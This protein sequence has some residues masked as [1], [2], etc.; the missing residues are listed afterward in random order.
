MDTMSPESHDPNRRAIVDK[1]NSLEASKQA[2]KSRH[3]ELASIS[4]LPCEVLAAIFSFLSVFAL[5]EGSGVLGWIYVA[6][7]CHRWRETALSHRRFRSHINLT[8][9]KLSLAFA[10]IVD[11]G[12]ITMS[13]VFRNG[14]QR[15]IVDE[16]NSLEASTRA[17][18]S[19]LNELAPISCLPFEVLT[20]I[21]TF[22]SVFAWNDC[23][24]ILAW[25][26]AAHICRRWRDAALNHPRFWSHVNFAK[27]TPV[28]MAEILSRAKMAPLHLETDFRS[29]K[30]E[31]HMAFK[32]QFETHISHT[33]HLKFSGDL[34]WHMG[35]LLN[36]PVPTLESLSLSHTALMYQ[37]GDAPTNHLNLTAPS[38]TSLK[39]Q[40]YDISWKSPL[41]KGLRIL[42]IR[43][44]S[45]RPE[46]N[47]WLDALNEMRQLKD[48]TFDNATP[49][50]P[51]TA[52]LISRTVTVPSLTYFYINDRSND[53]AHALAHIS[54]PTLT[55]LHVEVV[56]LRQDGEDTLRLIPFVARHVRALQ[57]NKPMRSILIAGER[58]STSV[59]T[60]ATPGVDV[61]VCGL[62]TLGDMTRSARFLFTVEGSQKY[63]VS[64]T[65]LDTLL[66]LLPMNSISTLSA[67]NRTRLSKESWL[68]HASRLPMLEQARLAP[69]AVRGFTEMLSEDM[70]LNS[71][72][73]RLAMLT[74]LILLD[75]TLTPMR[76]FRLRDILIKCMEQGVPLEC[77]DLRTCASA[78]RTIQ[79]FAEIMVDVQE[80]LAAQPFPQI[81]TESFFKATESFFNFQGGF[82][83]DNEAEFD[84]EK[85][86]WN[87]EG[88][89]D[90]N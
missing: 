64:T 19:R 22:L 84:D 34:K 69:T 40:C 78:N 89:E 18:K 48:L 25:I 33:R 83:Y 58:R 28:G 45:T 55:W 35:P 46:L 73:P 4:R 5:N 87:G 61:K 24:G 52:P 11:S 12:T 85:F 43:W 41:L 7:V 10:S 17:L 86:S 49:H 53:C 13:P 39:L 2:L 51:P 79:L 71:D 59:L 75:V 56:S 65:F 27:L 44:P 36:S 20:G 67:L 57:D 6:H 54:L 14:I 60:W 31:Y 38:L 29:C 8:Q 74:K 47:E 32:R 42:E 26:Y 50:A 76:T 70:P 62:D 77:I 66:T 81:L 88:D 68:G 23:S 37:I 90:D 30:W 16:I 21:F 63:G 80:P 15:A 82:E 9:A 3:N 1:I 72:G